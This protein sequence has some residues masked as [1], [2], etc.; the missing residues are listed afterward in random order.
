MR[1]AVMRVME[2]WNGEGTLEAV[3]SSLSPQAKVCPGS[4]GVE[5]YTLG[6]KEKHFLR[7]GCA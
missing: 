2:T 3:W 4:P 1:D 6:G 5:L 7:Q